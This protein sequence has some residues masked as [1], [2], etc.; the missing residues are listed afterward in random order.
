[1]KKTYKKILR[2]NKACYYK[3]KLKEAGNDSSKVWKIINQLTNRDKDMASTKN[4]VLKNKDNEII[5]DN[6]DI[7]NEF[8]Y[9]YTNVANC[10]ELP[11]VL[12][13]FH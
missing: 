2:Q 4:V 5:Y 12:R 6:Q 7:A 13:G 11:L 8:N 10:Y 9:Y 1:M 3:E